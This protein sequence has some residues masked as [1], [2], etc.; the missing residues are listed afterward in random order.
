MYKIMLV[1]DDLPLAD[2]MK[3]QLSAY[4]HQVICATDFLNVTEE[5]SQIKPDLVL[6]D[7]MLPKNNGYYFCTEIRKISSVPIIFISSASENMNIVMACSCGGDDF[8]AKPVDPMVL[9]A[10]VNAVLRR[11]YEMN[12]EK[13]TIDFYGATLN[14]SDYTLKNENNIVELTKNEF[15]ILEALL[16][17]RGKIVSRD[18]LMLRLWQNDLFVEENTLTVNVGRLRKKLEEC[19]LEDVIVTKHGSGYI[20]K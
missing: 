10:K 15:R 17:N 2:A 8:I 13:K 18:N 14:L 1:E 4:G 11:T 5:F 12:G 20:I 16:E 9:T 19:G 6:L 3:N 7:I